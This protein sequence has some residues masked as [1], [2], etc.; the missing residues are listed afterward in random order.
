MLK[1]KVQKKIT[2]VLIGAMM[3]LLYVG[4]ASAAKCDPS[5]I[6]QIGMRPLDP[7]AE[8]SY[9]VYVRCK[10]THTA[11]RRYF[12]STALGESGYATLL[13]AYSLGKQVEL[14]VGGYAGNSL[15]TDVRVLD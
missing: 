8:T 1:M 2:V 7:G 9:A 3:A 14:F 6:S 4:S 11:D 10:A 12:L 13:T 15:I 5:L